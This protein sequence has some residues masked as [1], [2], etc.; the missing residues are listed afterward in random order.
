VKVKTVYDKVQPFWHNL[1]MRQT[2]I[3]AN[4]IL[5]ISLCVATR[6]KNSPV[7]ENTRK[8][9]ELY[10]DMNDPAWPNGR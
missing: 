3:I 9:K 8:C 4:R 1:Q 10:R 2:Y 5:Y 7:V 6:G